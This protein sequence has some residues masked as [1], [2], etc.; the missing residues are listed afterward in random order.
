MRR[1]GVATWDFSTGRVSDGWRGLMAELIARTRGALRERASR[2]AT[3]WAASCGSRCGSPGSG[4]ARSSTASRRP[5]A[6]SSGS[7]RSTAPLDKA[8][9]AWRAWRWPSPHE[10]ER[11]GAPHAAERHELLLRLPHPARGEAARDLRALRLLPRGGRLRGRGGRR[12]R[13]GPAALARRGAPRLRGPARDGARARARG[14]RGAL[15]DPAQRLRGRRGGLPHGPHHAALRDLRRPAGLLR[16]RGLGGGPRLD[17]DLRLRR[18]AHARVRGRAGPRAPAHE[19]P[20]RRRR[21]T[22]PAT[23]ST[24][25]S[26]TSPASA[27]RR[28]SCSRPR[29]TPARP[30]RPA[31]T[32]LLAFEAERARV[33]L[34]GRGLA[35]ARRR[36]R[37][38]MLAA[39]IMGAIY[40]EVLEEWAR[41]GHPVGGA[42]VQLGKPRKIWIALR[43][44]SRVR[45]GR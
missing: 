36:D 37:R 21:R 31:S 39:E 2:C 32:R 27:C 18:P 28:R 6:T 23:A 3:G 20:A 1:H 35:A 22:P 29:A 26:R 34:R 13:G 5:G 4:G 8:A 17:R 10:R 30:R 19:H 38:S 7:G 14:D 9:L 45:W 42:R 15:P 12:G 43:T 44:I 24:S 25:R 33:A 16:A 41:R 40:R 11:R